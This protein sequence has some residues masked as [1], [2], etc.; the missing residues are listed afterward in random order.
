MWYFRA[1]RLHPD[2]GGDPE[3]FKEVTHAYVYHTFP[4]SFYNLPIIFID[5]KYYPIQ[6]NVEYMIRA[7][8]LA[9]QNKAV[10]E[11]W[12]HR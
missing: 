10:W 5:M 11:E 12:I 7:V 6:R 8:K 9:F 1:L 3:L 4:L 2:K